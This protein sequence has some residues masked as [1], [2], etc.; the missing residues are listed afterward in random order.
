MPTLRVS[1]LSTVLAMVLL[2]AFLAPTLARAQNAAGWNGLEL[3]AN[4]ET[5]GVTATVSG[6]ANR[7][8]SVS[9]QWRRVGEANFRAGQPL[10]R[11]DASH[12][13]GSLFELQS[14]S[15]YEISATLA[16][17]DG[18]SGV[19]TQT[20][21]AMTRADVLVEPSLRSL[22]VAPSGNDDNDGLT[23][24]SAVRSIQRAADLAQAGDLVKVAPGLYHEAVDLPRSGTASQPIVFRGQGAGV[25][26]DG[27]V[28]LPANTPWTALGNGIHRT[29]LDFDTGHV[30]SE[31]GRLFRYAS[32]GDL[33]ALAAGAP[34]GF[35]FD[36]GNRQLSVKFADGST[37]AVHV[38]HV[39]DLGAGFT[40]DSRAFVRIEGFEFRNYGADEYGKGIYLRYSDDCIVR[41]NRFIDIGSSAVWAKGGSRNR[42]ED[43]QFS[44]TSIV[45]WPWPVTKASFA[46]KSS[47]ALTDQIGRGN[48]IRR[49]HIDGSF[50][51]LAPCGSQAPAGAF[52][53]ETD[54]Y[55]NTFEH[56]NDD[57]IE[58]DGYCANLRVF[59]N[60]IS[61][62]H[63]G[64]SVAP[65]APGPVWILRNI[66][67][68]LGN[69]RTSQ[70]DGYL[71]SFLKINS[72]YAQA[73]GPL[74]MYHNTVATSAPATEA[75]YLL[76]PGASTSLKSRNN[77]FL[78]TR[79]VWVKVNPIA[80]D[81]DHDLLYTS[82]AS[83]FVRWMGTPYANLAALRSATGL[84]TNGLSAPP[85]LL[86][87]GSGDLRPAPGSPLID[88][89]AVLAGIND[90]YAGA[91]P[92]IGAFEYGDSIFADGFEA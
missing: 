81:A 24:A 56:L 92:D 27:A 90:G 86:A 83:R 40:L 19:A 79:D 58:A 84:E 66:A 54:V 22:H 44:D 71:S 8:A 53:N 26:L 60:R 65:A 57:A 31:Q 18:V 55:R 3:F 4:L 59:A 45:S 37:P 72:G 11:V 33:Q 6:D 42:I 41:D 15:A 63:M 30:V 49:N 23:P 29:T 52:S 78:A 62:S 28:V 10:L 68:N 67:W 80:V 51:G 69:T 91:A 35:F 2:A 82:D 73:V 50:D 43:N 14:A 61:D 16:D 17:P 34:G 9:L 70:I 12:F 5:A 7:N 46:E 25:V 74:L 85:Q 77:L 47:I 1:P 38:L 89:G 13:V 36:T 87:P 39:A 48:V 20:A 75:L 32:A 21:S 76:N 88:H 64:V